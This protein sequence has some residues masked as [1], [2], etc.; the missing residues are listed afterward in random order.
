MCGILGFVGRSGLLS[1]ER[2]E[3]ALDR[4]AHRG[5]DDRGVY[6][7]GLEGGARV[8]LATGGFPFST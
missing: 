7:Q 4:L 5:P 6:S 8:L 2:F 3:K 1:D